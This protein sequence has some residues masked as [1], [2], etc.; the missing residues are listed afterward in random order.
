[1]LKF[2]LF[3]DDTNVFGTGHDICEL[4]NMISKELE[5]LRQ[6]F[7]AKKLSLNLSKTK[8]MLFSNR[9]TNAG[10]T[11]LIGNARTERNVAKF[12][13]VQI[14]C[15]LSWKDHIKLIKS[16]LSKRIAITHKVKYLLDH[17]SLKTLYASLIL[18]YLSYCCE[19]WGNTYATNIVPLYK[20]QKKAVR[21]VNKAGY[22][23][24][25][26]LL[27]YDMKA[28]KLKDLI[29]WKTATIM[30]NANKCLLPTNIQKLFSVVNHES[31]NT[32]QIGNFV[33]PYARTNKKIMCI[34]CY[35]VR[36]WNAI[37]GNIKNCKNVHSF[38]RRLK[39]S[40]IDEYANGFL[41][42]NYRFIFYRFDTV[43]K[44]YD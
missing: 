20:L 32:R 27:F 30:Y 40:V 8:F 7:V 29:D 1:M 25:T 12:L 38:K 39:K 16:K 44:L 26:N 34:S 21:V 14:D 23:D 5:K 43:L 2:I 18:P 36:L 37:N 4:C 42:K 15:K 33:T 10:V 41:K 19:I 24:H 17:T 11:I 6:W 9:R 31:V 28:L 22:R 3:T 35:G 13:G